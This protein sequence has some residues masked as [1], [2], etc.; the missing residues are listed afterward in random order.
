[1]RSEIKDLFT[2]FSTSLFPMSYPIALPVLLVKCVTVPHNPCRVKK[3]GILREPDNSPVFLQLVLL[4][5][6]LS[7]ELDK[8]AKFRPVLFAG[9]IR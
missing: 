7:I 5:H 4:G 8:I 2:K 9:I 1:M 3:R 6:R